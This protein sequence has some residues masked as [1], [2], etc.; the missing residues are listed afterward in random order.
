MDLMNELAEPL[1]DL[2]KDEES[3]EGA[4]KKDAPCENT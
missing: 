4:P 2:N 1:F 3:K